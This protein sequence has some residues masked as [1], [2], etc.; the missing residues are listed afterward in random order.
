ML[1]PLS[2]ATDLVAGSLGG[3]AG[4]L[5]GQPLDVLKVRQQAVLERIGL[6]KVLVDTLRHEG[7]AALF[8]GMALPIAS[9]GAYTS[10]SF[11]GYNATLRMMHHESETLDEA[12]KLDAFV[13]GSVG[14]AL[15]TLVTTPCE[16]IKISLQVDHSQSLKMGGIRRLVRQRFAAKGIA[17]L[18]SGWTTTLLRDT[19]A[20][21]LYFVAYYGVKDASVAYGLES[22]TARELLSGGISGV[23]CWASVIPIDVVKTRV[24]MDVFLPKGEQRYSGMMDCAQKIYKEEGAQAFVKGTVPLLL[25]A[26]P[27]S[28]ITFLVY[29]NALRMLTA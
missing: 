8:K 1:D 3:A 14:G 27:V 16:L 18:Y 17:G 2:V 11:A 15:S 10:L 22:R 29:E 26:F 25:R 24:Q 23:L 9:Q 19:P 21:G 7:P 12:T 20:T 6:S 13:A 5:V 28:A 4:I